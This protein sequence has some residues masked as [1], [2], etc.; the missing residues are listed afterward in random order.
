MVKNVRNTFLTVML[1]SQSILFISCTNDDNSPPDDGFPKP[2]TFEN[3]RQVTVQGY[4]GDE[5]EPFIS[6][7]GNILFF[8]NFNG[9]MLPNGGENDTDIHYAARVDDIT[10]Q[11]KGK[12]NGAS[13]NE[14]SNNNEIE[15]VPSLDKKGKIYFIRTLDYLNAQSPD[16]LSS[17]FMGDYTQGAITN[18]KSLPNLKMDRP[19]GESP[20]VGELNFDAEIHYDAKLL[21]FVEGIFSGNPLPDKA[22]IG[23]ANENNGLFEVDPDSRILFAEVNTDALEYAPS[24]STDNLELYFTRGI[25][26]LQTGFDFG[27]YVAERSSESDPWGNVKRIENITG[28]FLEAPSISFDGRLLYYHQKI[29]DEFKIFVA[30]RK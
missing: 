23:I 27:I 6:R 25:G 26:S 2:I 7:D 1:I 19:M 5:M 4:S 14:I 13:T 18:L 17:I 21:Y 11:Y 8:N 24:I 16:Y 30:Q 3:P 15:G 12:V 28:E 22:D 20:V 29:E 10:F 9:D